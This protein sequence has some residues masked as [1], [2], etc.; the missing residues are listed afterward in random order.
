L[1][2]TWARGVLRVLNPLLGRK[3][4]NLHWI[5]KMYLIVKI[6]KFV[7]KHWIE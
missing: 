7:D 3:M 5:N 6:K 1:N 2:Q 4:Q